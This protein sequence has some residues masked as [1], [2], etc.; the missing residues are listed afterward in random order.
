MRIHL[1]SD[2]SAGAA[3]ALDKL[4]GRFSGLTILSASLLVARS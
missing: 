4:V 3:A 2:G 1:Q